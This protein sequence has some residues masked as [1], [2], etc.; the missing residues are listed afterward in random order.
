M[1]TAMTNLDSLGDIQRFQPEVGEKTRTNAAVF[2]R[3]E[4]WRGNN[5]LIE[6][7]IPLTRKPLVVV[8]SAYPSSHKKFKLVE[9][10]DA[11]LKSSGIKTGRIG[12]GWP[13]NWWLYANGIYI[14]SQDWKTKQWYTAKTNIGNGGYVISGDDFLIIS[15]ASETFGD[16]EE[17]M[18]LYKRITGVK[19][20][21]T[22]PYM[23][24]SGSKD[25]DLYINYVP[26]KRLFAIN[27]NYYQKNSANIDEINRAVGGDIMLTDETYGPNFLTYDFNGDQFVTSLSGEV[28][29]GLKSRGKHVIAIDGYD[30]GELLSYNGGVRCVTNVL[31][32]ASLLPIVSQNREVM[33]VYSQNHPGYV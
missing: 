30:S 19:N 27:R 31:H 25:I 7:S 14:P 3:N 1:Y 6:T 23:V 13:R 12:V 21:W 9:S 4:E 20:V 18:N 2:F 32:D 28:A 29:K 10:V 33:E 8:G 24:G 11:A 26:W 22:L 16:T 17:A 15:K 5:G